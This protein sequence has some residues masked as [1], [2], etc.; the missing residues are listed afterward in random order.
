MMNSIKTKIFC[1]QSKP[2]RFTRSQ[3]EKKI[4]NKVVIGN[5]NEKLRRL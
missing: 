3:D 4:Q 2:A 5:L 1:L